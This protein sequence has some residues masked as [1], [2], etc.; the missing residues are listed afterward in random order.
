MA[1]SQ[2]S[3]TGHA[4]GGAALF[5]VAGLAEILATGIAPGNASLD[6]VDPVM[7][8]DAFWVWPRRPIQISGRGG[9][10]RAGL[11][12]SLGFGHVS[13]LIALVHPGAFEAALRSREGEAGVQAWLERA[14]ARLAAGARRRMAGM[15]GRAPL[16]EELRARRL[17]QAEAG[18]D[19]HEV[20]AAML[21]DPQARLGADGVYHVGRNRL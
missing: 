3:V 9:V 12:T 17:G 18:R 20:E 13:G 21:L 11:V 15:I 14:N 16:F 4:K 2:K 8:P 6:V 1:V 10:V 19:P 7:E 5:Q